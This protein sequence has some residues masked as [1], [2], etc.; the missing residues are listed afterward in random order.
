MGAVLCPRCQSEHCQSFAVLHA[1]GTSVSHSTSRSGGLGFLG[2]RGA[3]GGAETRSTVFGQ[4]AIGSYTAPPVPKKY[5]L[6]SVFSIFF[7]IPGVLSFFDGNS[8]LTALMLLAVGLVI[9]Y[10]ALRARQYNR[11]TFQAL[12]EAWS[13]KWMCNQ[14]GAV[15]SP[16]SGAHVSEVLVDS[17]TSVEGESLPQ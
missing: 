6:K 4:T 2:G 5:L 8:A 13:Q 15:F 9:G 17:P 11:T 10:F 12:Y 14:C 3:F 1:H 7:L 16:Q